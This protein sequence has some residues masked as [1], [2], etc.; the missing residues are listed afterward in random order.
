MPRRMSKLA[1]SLKQIGEIQVNDLDFMELLNKD[2]RDFE[3]SRT[4]RRLGNTKVMEWDFRNVMPAVNK[5]AQQEVDIAGLVR[6]TAHYKVMEWD[7]RSA[8]RSEASPAPPE[9]R[10]G[11]EEMQALVARLKD[12]LQYVTASLIDEPGHAQIKVA[13]IAPGVLRFTLVLV[14]RDVAIL[15]G[16]EGH[17]A[18][19]IR[20]MLKAAAGMHGV[21]VLLRIHSHEEETAL[22]AT[23]QAPR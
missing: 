23:E 16:R 2:I 18:A 17:T 7:F 10:L 5:L 11:P 20:R 3:L 1:T 21:P 14:Q 6:R 13:E 8:L 9:K 22:A 4:L 19:A 12:F 15:I